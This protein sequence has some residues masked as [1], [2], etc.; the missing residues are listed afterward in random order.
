MAIL[1]KCKNFEQLKSKQSLI[2]YNLNSK[3]TNA[4]IFSFPFKP[5]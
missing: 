2:V 4:Q 3:V 1:N 5:Q